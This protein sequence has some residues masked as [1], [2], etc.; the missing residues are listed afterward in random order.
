[1]EKKNLLGIVLA[2]NHEVPYTK[3]AEH[4]RGHAG[5]AYLASDP[6]L[7]RTHHLGFELLHSAIHPRTD[8]TDKNGS[9]RDDHQKQKDFEETPFKL[10][11][12]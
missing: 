1:V 4:R 11:R 2:V 9:Q 3:I 7:Q 12:M 6:V 10:D 8:L 5:I